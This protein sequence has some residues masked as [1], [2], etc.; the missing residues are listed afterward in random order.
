[1]Y[2]RYIFV[3]H[4][5]CGSRHGVRDPSPNLPVDLFFSKDY[6]DGTAQRD[7]RVEHGNGSSPS[8]LPCLLCR[9][10]IGSCRSSSP[11][12]SSTRGTTVSGHAM[13]RSTLPFALSV[14]WRHLG[15]RGCRCLTTFFSST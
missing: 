8:S 4:S 2:P 13:A 12:Y 3:S 6:H 9:L 10:C 11:L 15:G 5:H 14:G 7:S 1:M